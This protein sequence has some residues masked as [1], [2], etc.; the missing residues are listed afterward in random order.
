MKFTSPDTTDLREIAEEVEWVVGAPTESIEL[1]EREV[2]RLE[3]RVHRIKDG[4]GKRS[5]VIHKVETD[6]NEDARNFRIN[7]A[8]LQKLLYEHQRYAVAQGFSDAEMDVLRA[9]EFHDADRVGID[10]IMED[11]HA[12]E[13]SES[14]VYKSLRTL[15]DKDLIKKIRPGVYQYTGPR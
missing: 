4:A 5:P 7:I 3:Q 12:E 11:K 9:V 10:E 2:N 8:L 15:Q 13:Y 14:T 6:P 1:T